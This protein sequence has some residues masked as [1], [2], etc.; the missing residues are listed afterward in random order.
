MR[1]ARYWN[2]RLMLSASGVVLCSST[3]A[4]ILI[5]SNDHRIASSTL[6][7]AAMISGKSGL[8]SGS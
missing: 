6:A 5:F 3:S 4:S 1:E 2:S 7:R 8:A